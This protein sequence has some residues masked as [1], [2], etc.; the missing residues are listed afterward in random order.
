MNATFLRGSVLLLG[1]LLP[2]TGCSSSAW[3]SQ[4]AAERGEAEAQLDLGTRYARGKGVE[5]ND[6]EAAKWLRKAADQGLARAQL[7]IGVLYAT[8][9]GVPRDDAEAARWYRKAADQ[10]LPQAQLNLGL[11]YDL[12]L[13]VPVDKA[14]AD[15]WWRTAA[16]QGNP[17]S[18]K[19]LVQ[20]RAQRWTA[21]ACADNGIPKAWRCRKMPQR[22]S[23]RP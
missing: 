4:A 23:P 21:P 17:G 22:L 19:N 18:A 2:I 20:L 11:A 13:G 3:K 9:R 5:R 15:S 7:D 10:G 14:E 1:L 16:A 8:G 6:A 12:G